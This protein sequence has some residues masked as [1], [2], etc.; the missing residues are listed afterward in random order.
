MPFTLEENNKIVFFNFNESFTETDFDR[1]IAVLERFLKRKKPF[2]FI[3]DTSIAKNAPISRGITLAKWMRARKSALKEY[4]LGSSIIISNE[5]LLKVLRWVFTKQ[6]PISPNLIT[7]NRKEAIAFLEST[8][9][10]PR[11]MIV[12][13]A[14]EAQEEIKEE[15]ISLLI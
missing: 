10:K 7:N 12:E 1:F 14:Q 11:V 9:N 3:V 15:E 2:S 4:L 8:L 6:K 13:E 5:Q